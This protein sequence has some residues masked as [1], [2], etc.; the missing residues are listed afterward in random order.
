[1]N[2]GDRWFTPIP[3]EKCH[4]AVAKYDHFQTQQ[5]TEIPVHGFITFRLDWC[6]IVKSSF[7]E[8]TESL[9]SVH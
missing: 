8:S 2:L 9:E 5:D 1:M 6:N 7:V 3:S 4:C